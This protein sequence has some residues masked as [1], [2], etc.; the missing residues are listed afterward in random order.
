MFTPW[1]PLL[2][3]RLLCS[4]P[5]N[6]RQLTAQCPKA[7]TGFCAVGF[8]CQTSADNL[9]HGRFLLQGMEPGRGHLRLP[10]S[11]ILQTDECYP[12]LV[13]DCLQNSVL[14]AFV[15]SC[16]DWVTTPRAVF[17]HSPLEP[18]FQELLALVLPLAADSVCTPRFYSWYLF[19]LFP[20]GNFGMVFWCG[21][22]WCTEYPKHKNSWESEGSTYKFYFESVCGQLSWFSLKAQVISSLNLCVM[23]STCG[24]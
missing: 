21:V 11:P 5:S 1:I 3:A 18:T 22:R 7:S 16:W 20:L 17:L 6:C 12:F 4:P 15:V 8:R 24:R 9:K 14:V 23:L 2:L 13:R 19:P 10:R